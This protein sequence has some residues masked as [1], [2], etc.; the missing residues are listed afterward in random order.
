MEM[1]R[2]TLPPQPGINGVS[3]Y[4]KKKGEPVYEAKL[5][6]GVNRIEIEVVAE[7]DPK[8]AKTGAAAPQTVNGH[9]KS[10]DVVDVE[11]CTIFVHL[12]KS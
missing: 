3:G 12:T 6:P 2:A 7:K 10:G 9:S 1:N 8:S 5:G 4:E 11:K